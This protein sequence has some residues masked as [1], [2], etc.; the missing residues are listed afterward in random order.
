MLGLTSPRHIS[1][2]PI[3]DVAQTS[4]MRKYRSVDGGGG[5]W[6]DSTRSLAAIYGLGASS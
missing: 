3:R 6:V 1:T 5:G 4:Q 2:L